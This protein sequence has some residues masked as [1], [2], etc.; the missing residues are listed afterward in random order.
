LL[1]GFV[2]NLPELGARMYDK[3]ELEEDEYLSLI[4]QVD[5]AIPPHIRDVL[6]YMSPG[7]AQVRAWAKSQVNYSGIIF[8]QAPSTAQL[9]ELGIAAQHRTTDRFGSGHAKLY[10]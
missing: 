6:M 3:P 2:L 9:E 8:A 4:T 5:A 10:L 1:A 7:S